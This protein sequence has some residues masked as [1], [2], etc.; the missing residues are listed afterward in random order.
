MLPVV[1]ERTAVQIMSLVRNKKLVG[2]RDRF[3]HLYH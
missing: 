3:P 2:V 1:T